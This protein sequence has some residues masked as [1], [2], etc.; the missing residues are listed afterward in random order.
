MY[1]SPVFVCAQASAAAPPPADP[2]ERPVPR[3]YGFD[4][5]GAVTGGAVTGGGL[6]VTGGGSW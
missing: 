1:G 2:R 3:P 5:A 4:G 6:V